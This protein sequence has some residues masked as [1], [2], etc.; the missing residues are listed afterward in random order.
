MSEGDIAVVV[1]TR[2]E[3]IKVLGLLAELDDRARLVHTG[4]HYDAAMWDAVLAELPGVSVDYR[5]DVGG[6]SR[7]EQIGLGVA[8]LTTH[9]QRAPARAVVVQGD[10]NSTLAGALAAN[11]LGIPVVHVEAGLRS[12]DRRM[13]EEINRILVDALADLCCAPTES[14]AA[15]L[16]RE[17]IGAERIRVTGNTLAEATSLL[18]PGSAERAA[19]LQRLDLHHERYVLVTLHRSQAVDDRDVLESFAGALGE[20]ATKATVVF[21]MHPRT[22]GRIEEFG[23]SRTLG[24]VRTIAPVTPRQFL[25]LEAGAALIASDSGGVQ[26]EACLLRRPLV[27]L[28]DTTERYE[29]VEAGWARLMGELDPA[30][31]LLRA[32]ADA[33]AWRRG[34]AH[35]TSP[36]AAGN[37]SAR[38]VTAI[39]ER[40]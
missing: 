13:P 3:A 2:P 15:L 23:L 20:L 29:L 31:V 1:G 11:S 36:Y 40:W 12:G 22:A 28:R 6:R 14:N 8:A 39:D 34:L 35:A 38:I 18:M 27:V 10:T 24:A 32:W 17:G 5:V 21:P 4:Q 9:F 30:D 7:G 25:A 16:R 33:D 26:E 19:T 37:A